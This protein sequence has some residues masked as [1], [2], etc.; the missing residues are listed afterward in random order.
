VLVAALAAVGCGPS[1][2]DPDAP[3]AHVLRERCSGC[4]RISAPGSMTQ[5]MWT[6]QLERMRVL[7]AQRGMPWLSPDEDAALRAYLARWAGMS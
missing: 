6:V 4:H 7:Y 2:P 3:G 1:L 5:E